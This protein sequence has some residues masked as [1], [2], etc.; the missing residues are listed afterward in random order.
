LPEEPAEHGDAAEVRATEPA[1]Q[2]DD[3]SEPTPRR[4]ESENGGDPGGHVRIV[5][6]ARRRERVEIVELRELRDEVERTILNV[7]NAITFLRAVLVPVIF[8]LLAVDTTAAQW[9]AFA[10][11]VFAAATDTIDGWV[12]RRWYGVTRWGQF[13]D[14]IADKLLVIGTLGALAWL[15]NLP[16]WAVIVIAVREIAVT[17]LRLR[18]IG[19]I[20]VVMPASPWGKSK[21]L[22]QLVAVA[23]YLLPGVA[24][25]WRLGLLY[26][27]V[28]LTVVSGVDYA[29]KAGSLVRDAGSPDDE[30]PD[31]DLQGGV[32]P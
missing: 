4:S 11:F 24:A 31:G 21:T 8:V 9:W 15:A 30:G 1:D 5:P 13:A 22:S 7:P 23:V 14:P 6:G 19:Q 16:W 18:L 28:V 20:D 12:A 25:A 26:V 29:F 2:Q 10:I 27:A 3:T 32:G 17:V